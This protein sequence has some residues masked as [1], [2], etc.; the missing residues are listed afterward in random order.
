MSTLSHLSPTPHLPH[1]LL[2]YKEAWAWRAFSYTAMSGLV[3]CPNNP[4]GLLVKTT[5]DLTSL[6][7]HGVCICPLIRALLQLSSH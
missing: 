7:G 5:D 2:I 1:L 4:T 3:L 6:T